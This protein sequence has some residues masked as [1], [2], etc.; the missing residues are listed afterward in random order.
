M[1]E[2]KIIGYKAF[3]KDLKCQG[4][5]FEIGKTFKHDGAVSLCNSGFHFC[6]NPLRI[7]QYKPPTS[8]FAEIE[9]P[10]E[11]GSDESKSVCGEI[12][13]K[14]ELTLK[15]IFQ[16]GFKMIFEKVNWKDAKPQTHGYYSAAVALGANSKASGGLGSW[17]TL[18]EW[19]NGK[20]IDVKTAKVD[21]KKIKA[22][23]FYSLVRG[24]FKAVS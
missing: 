22:G 3:D 15:A 11:C 24:R 17:I 12:A 9:T 5:Q 2:E 19:K 16:I 1:S 20:R 14:T 7:F 21:G 8:R 23:K 4:F 10:K 6:K 13:I 18:D